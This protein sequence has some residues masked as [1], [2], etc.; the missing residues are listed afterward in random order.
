MFKLYMKV[1][2]VIKLT[3]AAVLKF[4]KCDFICR[5]IYSISIRKNESI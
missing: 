4:L 1:V 2:F 5:T 3:T